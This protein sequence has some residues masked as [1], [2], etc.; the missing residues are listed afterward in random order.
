MVRPKYRRC[1]IVRSDHN[2]SGVA[3][4]HPVDALGNLAGFLLLPGQAHDMKGGPN[5]ALQTRHLM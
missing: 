3:Y 5:G 1:G 4:G 2:S